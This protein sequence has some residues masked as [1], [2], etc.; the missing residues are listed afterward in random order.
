[1]LLKILTQIHAFQG[2]KP[3]NIQAEILKRK[4]NFDFF[5]LSNNLF[6]FDPYQQMIKIKRII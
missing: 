4:D 1:M 6:M 3:Q 2:Y 5:F